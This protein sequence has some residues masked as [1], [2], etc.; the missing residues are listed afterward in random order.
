MKAFA[1]T[2]EEDTEIAFVDMQTD[3]LWVV[4]CHQR[5]ARGSAD[6]ARDVEVGQSHPLL[7]EGV[8]VGGAILL[9]PEAAEVSIAH[10]IHEDEDEVGLPALFQFESGTGREE[11][12]GEEDGFEGLYHA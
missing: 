11:G 4:A 3:S 1:S 10:V 8:E 9:R 2:R 7:R 12:E 5:R 6:A